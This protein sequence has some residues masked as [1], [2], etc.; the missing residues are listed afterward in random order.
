MPES[1]ET[2]LGCQV[3]SAADC[4]KGQCQKLAEQGIKVGFW[5]S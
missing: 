3:G 2:S 1:Q 5:M 4:E